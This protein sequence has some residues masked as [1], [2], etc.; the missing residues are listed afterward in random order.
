[1]RARR[2]RSTGSHLDEDPLNLIADAVEEL[3]YLRK[4]IRKARDNPEAA[5]AAVAAADW[6]LYD[7][8]NDIENAVAMLR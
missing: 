3:E 1:M 6:A 2:R 4:T 5:M 7:I 8:I